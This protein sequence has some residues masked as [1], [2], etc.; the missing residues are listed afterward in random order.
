MPK[1]WSAL[2]EPWSS[3]LR[4]SS[5]VL[6]L[7]VTGGI[8]GY[9]FVWIAVRQLGTS[10]YGY[11]ELGFS[12]LGI[13]SVLAK[14]GLDGL[15]LREVPT[16][17]AEAAQKIINQT[18]WITL[19][20]AL[21]LAA[22]L[23]LGSDLL[24]TAYGAH[25][26]LWRHVAFVLPI[27]TMLQ[28]HAEVA[29]A[30]QNWLRYGALQ[31][32]MMLGMVAVML[33]LAGAWVATPERA[34]MVLGVASFASIGRGILRIRSTEL[35]SLAAYRRTAFAML[36]TGTLFMVMT[37]TDTLM[38]GYFLDAESVAAY[39]IPFKIATLITFSQFAVNASIGPRIAALWAQS[40]REELQRM[41]RRV[42]LLNKLAGL[43][44]FAGVVLLAPWLLG[45]F[46]TDLVQHSNVLRILALGQIVFVLS[47][48]V[49]YLLDM[50]GNEII[51]RNTMILASFV[52][53]GL[54]LV[55]IPWLGIVG[56]AV[57]TSGTMI[58]WNIWAVAAVYRHTG[59][60]TFAIWRKRSNLM[61]K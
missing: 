42:T 10:G 29:R 56:A 14:M 60:R 45:F 19:Q 39:R 38:V 59:I 40:D 13:L 58:L 55:L 49:V 15:L 1:I 52:N 57:A 34:L 51:A 23:W 24:A 25:P 21:L 53:F 28:I 54:N 6:V 35:L 27:W 2:T 30:R 32:S 26:S 47:G 20:V 37:W 31:N 36:V 3:L 17:T 46:G 11:F 5:L 50:T 16:R 41:V 44:A 22:L 9:G 48:P 43:P 33:S 12:V 7:K 18:I 61:S 4:S 8:A